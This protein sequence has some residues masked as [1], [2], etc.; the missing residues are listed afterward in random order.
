MTCARWIHGAISHYPSF[1][2]CSQPYDQA[3]TIETSRKPISTSPVWHACVPPLS[4]SIFSVEK[5]TYV[6]VLSLLGPLF[7]VIR[8]EYWQLF[9]NYYTSPGFPSSQ[10]LKRAQFR[11]F[12]RRFLPSLWVA[13]LHWLG[14]SG[15]AQWQ[16]RLMPAT[17]LEAPV[18]YEATSSEAFH[19]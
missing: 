2:N 19:R 12:W 4:T 6:P 15:F 14:R 10:H 16:K 17:E 1:Y 9:S 18:F 11:R 8:K 5:K 3:P 13:Q 7:S